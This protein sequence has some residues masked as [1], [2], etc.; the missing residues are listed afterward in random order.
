MG[1]GFPR[2]IHNEDAAYEPRT[3]RELWAC[4]VEKGTAS[5]VLEGAFNVFTAKFAPNG[6]WY[7]YTSDEGR[8]DSDVYLRPFPGPG[9]SIRVS[10]EG[11][12]SPRWREDGKELFYLNGERQVVAVQVA[13]EGGPSL[14][15]AGNVIAYPGFYFLGVHPDGQRFLMQSEE[16][17]RS[18]S[19]L[20]ILRNW[21][22]MLEEPK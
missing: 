16:E 13:F 18:G 17:T 20:M 6:K 10:A 2:S 4:D 11:G 8:N 9:A 7:A 3:H 22:G 5:R 12:S 15:P 1:S 19:R 14:A 21:V